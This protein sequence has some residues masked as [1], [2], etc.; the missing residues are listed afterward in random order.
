MKSFLRSLVNSA[1]FDIR[2]VPRDPYWSVYLDYPVEVRQRWGYGQAPHARINALLEANLADFSDLL[3]QFQALKSDY[4]AVP[5]DAK[6]P[7]AVSWNN[8]WFSTLDAAAL[9]AFIYLRKPKRYLEIGSGNSTKFARHI[10]KSRSLSTQVT[11]IDPQPRAE[12]DLLCDDILR[13]PLETLDASRFDT[14]EQGDILFFDGSHRVFTNS[15]TTAFFFDILPRLKPGVL[16]HIHDIYWPDDYPP[17]WNHRY[18]SEQYLLGA[19]L[20]GGGQ[21]IR[22]VMPNYFVTRHPSTA[23]LVAA[24]GIP[25]TYPG[26]NTPGVSFWIETV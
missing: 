4:A 7:T 10:I 1:G 24:L 15:D 26:S 5:A 23:P 14:L 13:R 19:W 16:V 3:T 22:V 8:G 21:R 20:M 17:E 6:T 18:Y 25:V 9:M 12:I 11:S 2:R